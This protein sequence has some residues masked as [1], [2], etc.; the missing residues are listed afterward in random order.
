LS[1]LFLTVLVSGCSG[2]ARKLVFQTPDK[3][4]PLRAPRESFVDGNRRHYTTWAYDARSVKDAH[5]LAFKNALKQSALELGVSV[6]GEDTSE[7]EEKNGVY[8]YKFTARTET[9]TVPT[10]FSGVKLEDRYDECFKVGRTR[11]CNSYVQIGIP[12]EQLQAAAR[13][14]AGKVAFVFLC[15][16]GDGS[17]CGSAV[18]EKIRESAQNA[19]LFLLDEVVRE[20]LAAADAARELN[21]AHVF[22][23]SIGADYIGSE[24]EAHFA[25]A[26][27]SARLVETRHGKTLAT[28]D[29]GEEKAGAYS[30]ADALREAIRVITKRLSGRIE[31][32]E[33]FK[34]PEGSKAGGER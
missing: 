30:K 6:V 29:A 28:V 7:Q 19:G 25:R 1:A 10:S 17:A 27:A 14:V 8:T 24:G 21:A 32:E 9:R 23:V 31:Y 4:A 18:E 22:K 2:G 12:V 16:A 15:K 26:E 33:F 13:E 34:Q 5:A 11:Q 3:T 20:E